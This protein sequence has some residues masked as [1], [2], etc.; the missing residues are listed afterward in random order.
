VVRAEGVGALYVALPTTLVM[1]VPYRVKGPLE[2]AEIRDA[3]TP[4]SR[5][6]K[7]APPTSDVAA[8]PT[9]LLRCISA[10]STGQLHAQVYRWRCWLL[11]RTA[12]SWQLLGHLLD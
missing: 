12:G 7:G 8:S 6:R 11:L 10:Q 5:K 2:N 3:P 9:K 4:T 1:N